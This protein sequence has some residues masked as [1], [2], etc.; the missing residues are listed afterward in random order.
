[1]REAFNGVWSGWGRDAVT[2]PVLL[3][4]SNPRGADAMAERLWR[5]AG[6]EVVQFPADWGAHGKAAGFRRNQE[7]VDAAMV[8]RDHGAVV[9]CA[10]F[11]ELCRAPACGQRDRQQLGP[12]R[13]GHFSHGTVH[14]RRSALAAGLPVVDVLSDDLAG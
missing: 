11:L 9:S 10:A 2:R 4:G 3:S 12:V 8:L 13:P 6:L 1:M 14:C 5:S 7:M